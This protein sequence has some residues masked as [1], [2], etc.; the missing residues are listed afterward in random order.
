MSSA[1]DARP[2]HTPTTTPGNSG[3]AG[4]WGPAQAV[5]LAAG[6]SGICSFAVAFGSC[7]SFPT[8]CRARQRRRTELPGCSGAKMAARRGRR[9]RVVPPASGGSG[10]DPGGGVRGSSWGSRSQ[11]P[12]GTVGAMSGGEQ[13]R[14]WR[15]ARGWQ[16]S[17]VR[18]AVT[19]GRRGR[20]RKR[21]TVCAGW[22]RE[23]GWRSRPEPRIRV[24]RRRQG[25]RWDFL[26]TPRGRAGHGNRACN[27]GRRSGVRWRCRRL[28]SP[29]KDT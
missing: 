2:G 19:R 10:P 23:S 25:A 21:S 15:A 22:P 17:G 20:R 1:S 7:S 24:E 28:G 29:P 14:A 27:W 5:G 11:T 12:Y 8:I 3:V 16:L 6:P 18:R 13:V 9:D 4:G 26:G